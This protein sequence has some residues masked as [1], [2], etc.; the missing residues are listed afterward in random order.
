[1][2]DWIK[3]EVGF[4]RARDVAAVIIEERSSS[5]Y[6]PSKGYDESIEWNVLLVVLRGGA[7]IEIRDDRFSTVD[8]DAA[9]EVVR[10]I[11]ARL[12]PVVGI[13]S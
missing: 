10:D 12:N 8:L 9:E 5:Y 7:K 11:E 3:T 1:V 13:E 2:N 4:I 6:R